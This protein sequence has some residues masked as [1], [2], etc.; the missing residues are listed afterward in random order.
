MAGKGHEI[1]EARRAWGN[2]QMV[3]KSKRGG[4]ARAASDPRGDGVAWY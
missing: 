4:S 3:F 1:R 2:M